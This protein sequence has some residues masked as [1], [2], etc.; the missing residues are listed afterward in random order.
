MPQETELKLLIRPEDLPRLLSHPALQAASATRERLYN[1]YLDTPD[2]QLKARRMAVRERR[3]GRR[4]WL[5]VKTAGSSTGG[6]S[7]RGE[8]EAPTRPGE[9]DFRA[10]L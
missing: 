4:T 5:T 10:L 3:I 1:T 7:V 8:W 9:P 6:M 2:L